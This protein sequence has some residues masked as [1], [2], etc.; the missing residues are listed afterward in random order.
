MAGLETA[1]EAV[2]KDYM[3]G[4]NPLFDEGWTGWPK[5][6][7]QDDVLSWFADL[8]E[9]LAAFAEHHGSN[10]ACRRRPLAQPN[11]PIQGSTG[12]RKLDV[13][14]MNDTKADKDSRCHWSQVLIPGQL[15]SNPLADKASK[16]W[17]DSE[18]GSRY[19]RN[20]SV[21]FRLHHLRISHEDIG[22]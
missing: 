9:K 4:S 13:G 19:A 21:R 16:A 18:R 5:E 22:V 3:G 17:L 12:E 20:P 6:A 7:N 10:P 1:A 14:F 2:L 11:K 15:K 8:C